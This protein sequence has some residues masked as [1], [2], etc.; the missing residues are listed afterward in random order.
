MYITISTVPKVDTDTFIN[1]MGKGDPTLFFS[2][3]LQFGEAIIRELRSGSIFTSGTN[4]L[5]YHAIDITFALR[6]SPMANVC[7]SKEVKL[8]DVPD[9]QRLRMLMKQTGL[10]DPDQ[11]LGLFMYWLLLA[12]QIRWMEYSLFVM[13]AREKRWEH[14]H[15]KPLDDVRKKFSY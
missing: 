12:S 8:S 1:I 14:F 2:L 3:L 9:S 4:F 11:L 7:W 5:G 6:A 13:N 15:F 10:H